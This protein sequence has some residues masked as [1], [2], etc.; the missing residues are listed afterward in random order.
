MDDCGLVLAAIHGADHRDQA[1][2]GRPYVWPSSRELSTI[3]VG[4]DAQRDDLDTS[5]PFRV[6]RELGVQLTPVAPPD[7]KKDFGL[8]TELQVGLVASEAASSFDALTRDGEPKGVKGWPQFHMLGN[9]LTA[10]DYL[11]FNRLRAVIMRR[12]DQM[13]QTV[14]LYLGN[15]SLWNSSGEPDD[16]WDL[17]GN[18]TGHPMVTFPI[19]FENKA[20][21]LMP[22]PGMLM[23]RLYDETTLLTVAHACEQ[24]VQL[25]ERPRLDE[26]LSQEDE[27]LADEKYIDQEK[28][29]SN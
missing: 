16:Q 13:M 8:T 17:Y 22:Q 1:A 5:E 15:E 2:V 6:L 21:V 19:Q 9:F 27:I 11:K 23:G 29:Y 28:Y 3:K 14:D 7:V 12:I 18:Q 25:K 24:H 10:V 26:F 4:Y 20:G